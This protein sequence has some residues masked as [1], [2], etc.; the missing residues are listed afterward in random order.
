MRHALRSL[1][2]SPG[3]TI[4]ALLTLALGIGVNTAMFSIAHALLLEPAPYPD[5]E[6]LV[7]LYRTS[8]QSDAWPHSL[9]N[10]NDVR[11]QAESFTALTAFSWWS[12][13]LAEPGQPAERLSGV[14]ATADLFATLG[15]QPM[16]GRG[17]TAAEQ[18]PGQ[19]RVV[20]LS[21]EFWRQR[22]TSDPGV[23]GR[24]LRI[25][26]EPVTVIGVMP[27]TQDYPVFWGRVQIW[28]P[29]SGGAWREDRGTHWLHAIG[30]LRPGVAVEQAQ[31]EI[32]AIAGRLAEA[33]PRY[34]SVEGMRL[35]P[36]HLTALDPASRRI[37]WLTLGLAGVVLLIAC[38]NL[39]NLQLARSAARAR[40][41][42]V[43]AALGATRGDL[44]RRVLAE[45]TLLALAGGA[46]GVLLS[47]WITDL[48]SQHLRINDEAG[49][50]FPFAAPV[51]GFAFVASFVAVALAGAVPAWFASRA[52]LN[53]VMKQNARGATGDRSRHRLRHALIVAEIAFALL[54]L[55]GAGFF[56]RGL[57]RLVNDD[58]GWQPEGLLIGTLTLPEGAYPD[59][60]KRALF[61]ERLL[62]RVERLPGVQAAALSTWR[63]VT[64]L[65][66]SRSFVVEGQPDPEPGRA[67]LSYQALVSPAFF[68]TLGIP[69]VE[70]T[71]FARDL[72]AD[73]PR[74]VVINE[75]MARRF[76]PNESAV[77]RRIG[78]TDASEREWHEV[79]G[80]VRDIRDPARYGPADTPWQ[81][82]RPLVQ[83][84]WGYFTV[85]LRADAPEALAEPLR[86]AVAE[87]DPDLPVAELRTV[88]DGLARSRHHLQTINQLL[89]AFAALGLVLASVGLYGVISAL[90]VQRTA[91]FGVR[92]ALGASPRDV[93]RLVL[94]R[95]ARLTAVGIGLGLL[96]AFAL[97]QALG[98]LLPGL[99]GEDPVAL[100]GV[101]LLLAGVAMLASF[102]PARRA[103][104]IDPIIA[105]RAE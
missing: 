60:P 98:R 100:A 70:G 47:L 57:Q 34:N 64:P 37:T 29:L 68:E 78:N 51:L 82:F 52:D 6:R 83:E 102:L 19:D 56:A 24:T 39:G 36:L 23:I 62:E 103:T 85:I 42:A 32:D 48:L 1:L 92:L 54:L 76:W 26:G 90:V 96:G 16:L 71:G 25:D 22:F 66:S 18:V 77:G 63:P 84:P 50:A 38:G 74:Q 72:P 65:A 93:L 89:V 44:M 59:E 104:R 21:H 67:P 81:M 69:F 46:L 9:P 40:E 4:T 80:V 88:V 2:Q 99:P 30:R 10:F 105:L 91:E 12:Y 11:D 7:R 95:G 49:H 20:V 15:V 28:R 55:A 5:A 33:Y 87:V 61:Q 75:S 35:A 53:T 86:R 13:G 14:A 3:F 31:A 41:Y 27:E 94:G 101:M 97:L 73:G 43:R 79:I 45:S 17:F 8:P 58:V